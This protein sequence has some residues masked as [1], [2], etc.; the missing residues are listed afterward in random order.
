[1]VEKH[2]KRKVVGAEIRYLFSMMSDEI[3]WDWAA[4]V[5]DQ[6]DYS[7][8]RQRNPGFEERV[9]LQCKEILSSRKLTVDDMYEINGID[10]GTDHEMYLFLEDAFGE[11]FCSQQ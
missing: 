10:F 9:Y 3:Y 2:L 8:F 6:M 5:R 4:V 7:L 11:I 1:M